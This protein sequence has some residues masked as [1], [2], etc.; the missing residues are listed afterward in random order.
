MLCNGWGDAGD[1][2]ARQA[3]WGRDN[4]PELHND[5]ALWA[6]MIRASQE[7]E[8]LKPEVNDPVI[9]R[10][11]RM[12]VYDWSGQ[13]HRSRQAGQAMRHA[14]AFCLR[15]LKRIVGVEE[16]VSLAKVSLA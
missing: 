3:Q 14:T 11:V 5:D 1:E 12:G 8:R 9:G 13:D 6:Y 15:L 4:Y 2:L 16:T 10:L 7:Y